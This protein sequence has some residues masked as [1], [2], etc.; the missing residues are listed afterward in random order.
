MVIVQSSQ[1]D[2]IF[3]IKIYKAKINN[4]D[5]LNLLLKARITEAMEED[6][7]G[8][9]VTNVGGWHS[10]R[11]LLSSGDVCSTLFKGVCLGVMKSYFEEVLNAPGYEDCVFQT[12]ANVNGEGDYN[13]SHEHISSG[14]LWV[15]VYYVDDGGGDTPTIFEDINYGLKKDT[16]LSKMPVSE[17]PPEYAV[18]VEP[19][20]FIIFP[21][22]LFHR[23]DPHN[24]PR[25]RITIAIN[26]RHPNFK[27]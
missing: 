25:D 14:Q 17:K 10:D 18:P 19:G 22:T 11:N 15:G 24:G 16:T 9:K 27:I 8:V 20:T 23:V 1:I 2:E 26:I 21:G 7:E 5:E 12:W 13:I 6:P 4:S 3:P